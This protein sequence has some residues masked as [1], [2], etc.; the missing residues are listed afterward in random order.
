MTYK[1]AI[2]HVELQAMRNQPMANIC[3]DAEG[4]LVVQVELPGAVPEQDELHFHVQSLE[5]ACD[6]PAPHEALEYLHRGRT[7]G[8]RELAIHDFLQRPR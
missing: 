2:S 1:D 8:R 6:I 5:L 3:V 4:M 7:T